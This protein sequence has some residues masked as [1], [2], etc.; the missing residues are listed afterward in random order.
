MRTE[1]APPKG[2]E[3]EHSGNLGEPGPGRG[4][5]RAI[6]DRSAGSTMQ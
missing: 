1:G 5:V 3:I 4:G 2:M 6:P